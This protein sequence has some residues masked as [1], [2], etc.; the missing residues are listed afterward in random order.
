MPLIMAEEPSF[1]GAVAPEETGTGE[2]TC[3]DPVVG[4]TR[5]LRSYEREP[6]GY[7]S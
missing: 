4:P 5:L 3:H 1:L 6:G 7:N 2:T